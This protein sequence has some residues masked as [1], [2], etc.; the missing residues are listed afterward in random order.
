MWRFR[1]I[2]HNRQLS[3]FGDIARYG[4]NANSSIWRYRHIWRKC[5][6][7]EL[8][9][10]PVSRYVYYFRSSTFAGTR[11]TQ[12]DIPPY[13]PYTDGHFEGRTTKIVCCVF[14]KINFK[15]KDQN[16]LNQKLITFPSIYSTDTMI[17]KSKRNKGN[18]QIK[19]KRLGYQRSNSDDYNKQNRRIFIK[20]FSIN[21]T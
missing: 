15:V 11:R 7:L 3:H 5:Q 9:I 16:S 8:A 20:T 2:W 14:E 17:S 10:S 18:L 13:S 4:E 12:R 1:H 19:T 21:E 6:V